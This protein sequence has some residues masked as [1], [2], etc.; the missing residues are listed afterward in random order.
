VLGSMPVAEIDLPQVMRVLEP[1]WRERTET[2]SRVRGRLEAILSWATVRGYRSG[3]NPA[4]WRGHLDQLLPPPSKVSAVTHHAAL[5]C[6]EVRAFAERLREQSGCG[7]RAL[8]F[9]MLTAARSGE[10]R[11]ADW[12]EI[13]L[14][15]RTWIVPGDRMKAGREHRVPLS[16][17]ATALLRTS[18]PAM[19]SGLL[20]PAARGGPLSDMT[21]SAVMRRMKVG[22][23]PHGLRSTFRDWCAEYTD[24]PSEVAEMALAHAIG[25][26]VEAAY[27]RGDLFEKR[28]QLMTQWAVF[29]GYGVSTRKA[30]QPRRAARN[31]PKASS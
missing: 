23:V 31:Q 11:G 30:A 14:A 20:F 6:S 10:V 15:E 17:A 16:V 25:D 5:Q 22:A 26:K 12:S 2:A 21:L 9:L 3:D 27:R 24:F 1:I 8:E 7:A 29:C 18:G 19:R 28:R 4:R 13:D